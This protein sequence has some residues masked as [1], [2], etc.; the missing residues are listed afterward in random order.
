MTE[1][2]PPGRETEGLDSIWK[3]RLLDLLVVIIIATLGGWYIHDVVRAGSQSLFPPGIDRI[4]ALDAAAM[5]NEGRAVLLDVRR[6]VDGRVMAR[7]AVH[8]SERQLESLLKTLPRG[9][10]LITYCDCAGD[11]EAIRIGQILENHGFKQVAVLKD[12]IYSWLVED[13]PTQFGK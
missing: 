11:A 13:L 5:V 10:S 12:G 2:T 7:G 9:H 3:R 1:A 6:N 8:A 4:S